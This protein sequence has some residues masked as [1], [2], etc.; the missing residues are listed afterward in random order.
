MKDSRIGI[1]GG[2]FDPVHMAHIALGKAAIEEAGLAKL[3]VMPAYIQ[4]FKQEKKVTDDEHRLGMARLAF[5]DVENAE[6]STFEIDRAEVSY[7]YDTLTELKKIYKDSEIF[8]ITGTDAFL[9]I[10]TWYK[11]LDLLK[12]FSFAVSSRPGC[13]LR[14]LDEKIEEY[15]KKYGTKVVKLKSGMLDISSSMIRQRIMDSKSVQGLV[16][17]GVERYIAEHGLYQRD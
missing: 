5:A 13:D 14:N 9:I 10:D 4:P 8:F 15:R 11:G 16:P 6:V 17:E 1:L 3:I 2:T 7:T 12:N